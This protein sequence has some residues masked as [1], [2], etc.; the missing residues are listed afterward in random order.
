VCVI[1][2]VYA[3]WYN[4]TCDTEVLKIYMHSKGLKQKITNNI[5]NVKLNFGIFVCPPRPQKG[6]KKKRKGVTFR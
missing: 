2:C 4:D 3:L 5:I 6:L 1:V